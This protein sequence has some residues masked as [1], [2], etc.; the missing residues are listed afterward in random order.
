MKHHYRLVCYR[1]SVA[2]DGTERVIHLTPQS[3]LMVNSLTKMFN[4]GKF[5][6]FD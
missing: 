5:Y 3:T 4:A 2:I 1:I 6:S